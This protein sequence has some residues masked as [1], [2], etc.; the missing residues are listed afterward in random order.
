MSRTI[1][2]L[3]GPNLNLLGTRETGHY[4]TQTL[5]EIDQ[6]LAA[7]GGAAGAVV[8]CFQSN[9][10]GALIDR[11]HAAP[12]AGIAFIII[13]PGAFTHTSIALRDA[14]AAV[15]IP[16]IEVHLSNVYRRETFRHHSYFSELA[17]GVIAGLGPTGYRCALRFALDVIDR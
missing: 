12:A 8:E 4:G 10:E 15:A 17:V 1:W 3:H 16:F 7:D 6:T 9:H 14:L 5:A 2:V 13:N 11:I